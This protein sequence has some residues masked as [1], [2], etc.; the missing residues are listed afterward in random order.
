MIFDFLGTWSSGEA[1]EGFETTKVAW[2]EKAG[3]MKTIEHPAYYRRLQ[4]LLAFDGRVLFL[5]Y[6][7]PPFTVCYE[8]YV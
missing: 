2:V 5:S 6:T 8:Q 7:T 3:S 4:Q 1:R